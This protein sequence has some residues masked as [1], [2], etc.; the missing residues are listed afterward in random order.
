MR[1]QRIPWPW[2]VGSVAAVVVVLV[3]TLLTHAVVLHVQSAALVVPAPATPYLQ[4]SAM[5][6]PDGGARLVALDADA[7]VVDVLAAAQPN[8]PI[9]PQGCPPQIQGC[10][11]ASVGGTA[12]ALLVLDDATGATRTRIP[13]T[14]RCVGATRATLLLDD[15]THGRTY[16]LSGTALE[17]FDSRSGACLGAAVL[18]GANGT[19]GTNAY[20][21]LVGAALTPDGD[22]LYLT[23]RDGIVLLD[24]ASGQLVRGGAISPSVGSLVAGPVLDL[25]ENAVFALAQTS[26]GLALVPFAADTLTPMRSMPLPVGTLLGP[27]APGMG[28]LLLFGRDG[29]VSQVATSMLVATSGA[30]PSLQPINGLQGAMALGWA[31]ATHGP[32]PVAL[33]ANAGGARMVTLLGT[34]AH[35]YAALPLPLAPMMSWQSLPI[36][37]GG[38]VLIASDGTLVFVRMAPTTTVDQDV[39]LLLARAALPRYLPDTN[40]QP[41][42]LAPATFPLTPG[43]AARAYDIYFSDLGWQGPY[44]GSASLTITAGSGVAGAYQVTYTIS[45]NQLFVR[46]HHWVV[47]VDPGGSARLVDSSGDAIP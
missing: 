15:P 37:A 6:R 42:F 11:S 27:F 32:G 36:D 40:Q 4:V 8:Q 2:A 29:T 5:V 24:P 16:A 13:L 1:R 9:T 38:V 23:Y 22:A 45:W 35:L 31:G 33:V 39:A 21:A 46:Q 12:N 7:G 44:T 26:A 20:G 34:S 17:T 18:P 41:P 43:T 47:R 30:R 14:G 25:P 10:V 3:A 28:A 19:G